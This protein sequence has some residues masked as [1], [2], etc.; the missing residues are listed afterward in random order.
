MEK[1]SDSIIIAFYWV[2]FS[3]AEF[4]KIDIQTILNLLIYEHGKFL[5]EIF[6]SFQSMDTVQAIF[7][8]KIKIQFGH[9]L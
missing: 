7:P 2:Y 3:L 9:F 1:K 4:C 8:S 6:W 5:S